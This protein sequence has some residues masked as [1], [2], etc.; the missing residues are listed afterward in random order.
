MKKIISLI[1]ITLSLLAFVTTAYAYNLSDIKKDYPKIKIKTQKGVN[2]YG[3]KYEVQYADI[4]KLH[5]PG[6]CENRLTFTLVESAGVPSHVLIT[7][8]YD[9]LIDYGSW[10][11]WDRI[12]IGTGNNSVSAFPVR[13]PER[14]TDHLSLHERLVYIIHDISD[15]NAWKDAILIRAKSDR[16]YADFKINQEQYKTVMDIIQR[17]LFTK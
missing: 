6:G 4:L 12:I 11:F 3:Q 10:A 2:D 15:F 8:Y 1:T 7:H 17:F 9:D 5:A 13:S 14:W 16:Y